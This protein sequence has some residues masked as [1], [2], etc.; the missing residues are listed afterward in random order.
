MRENMCADDTK[1]LPR[2]HIHARE[3]LAPVA[4]CLKYSWIVEVSLGAHDAI[5]A[6]GGD[7]PRDVF[8][9]EH[10]PVRKHHDLAR[11]MC[12]EIRDDVPVRHSRVV[13]LLLAR[14]TVYGEH[15]CA[16][17]DDHARVLQ[18]ALGGIEDANFGGDGDGE[19][20]VECADE[21]CDEGP[22]FLQEG[23]VAAFARDALRAAKVQVDCV[24]VWGDEVC[25]G[26]EVG[27]GVGAELDECGAV[28]GAA[29]EEGR[30]EGLG[31]VGGCGGEKA[32]VEHGRV[33]ECVWGGM[34]SG[35][36]APGLGC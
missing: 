29:V 23:A 34:P 30:L 22:V 21:G 11:E 35:E 26:E 28:R 2:D 18:G 24:A 12:P 20:L 5:D 13:A 32:G 25:G 36:E 9:P 15:R 6:G 31:A 4:R 16:G 7:T 10:I 14:A 17:R 33:T 8:L 27:G 1:V 3:T 19:V